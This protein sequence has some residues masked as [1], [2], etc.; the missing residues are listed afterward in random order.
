MIS[1]ALAEEKVEEGD[2]NRRGY[3]WDK[4]KRVIKE[5]GLKAEQ[6]E[7]GKE[8]QLDSP[9]QSHL[10]GD[11]DTDTLKIREAVFFGTENKK[12]KNKEKEKGEGVD[13]NR[14]V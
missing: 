2:D 5:I 7:R 13:K 8:M 3:G 10:S 6:K 9:E 1:I 12:G 4:K 11:W 14:A